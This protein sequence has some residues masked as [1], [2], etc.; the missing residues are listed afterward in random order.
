MLG[1]L[2]IQD[3]RYLFMMLQN[4]REQLSI[5]LFAWK[6]SFQFLNQLSKSTSFG[7]FLV[8]KVYSCANFSKHFIAKVVTGPDADNDFEVKFMK[9]PNKV[10]N[11]FIFPEIDDIA[12]ALSNPS[13][14][15]QQCYAGPMRALR[16]LPVREPYRFGRGRCSGPTWANRTGLI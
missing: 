7:N 14:P 2:Y 1:R 15:S 4:L 6:I 5:K 3:N 16:G 8:V 12:C 10:K 13:P 11:R 9:L